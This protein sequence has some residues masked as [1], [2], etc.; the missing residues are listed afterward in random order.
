MGDLSGGYKHP[1]RLPNRNEKDRE[2]L[3]KK[4]PKLP[5]TKSAAFTEKPE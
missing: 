2:D 3:R 5:K 4:R 1:F